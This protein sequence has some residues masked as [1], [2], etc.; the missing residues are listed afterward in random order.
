MVDRMRDEEAA[1]AAS[2]AEPI[3]PSTDATVVPLAVVRA[4]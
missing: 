2:E 3:R 1:A 4:R